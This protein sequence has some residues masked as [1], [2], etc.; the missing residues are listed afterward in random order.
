VPLELQN[1]NMMKFILRLSV[2]IF[3]GIHSNCI[4]SQTLED[5]KALYTKGEYVKAG[6]LYFL[7]YK[8]K[9]SEEAYDKYIALLRKEKKTNDIPEI[10]NL[11]AK[12][13]DAARMLA[14]CENIQIIDSVIVN[15]ADFLKS[16]NIL[17]K[18]SGTI[19]EINNLPVYENQLKDKRY[20]AKLGDERKYR[21]HSQIKLLNKWTD[22]KLLNLAVDADANDN[23]PFVLSDGITIYYASTGRG[24][25]GGYDLFVTRYNSSSDTY[26]KP[27]RLGMPFN[28]PYND[29]MLAIDEHNNVGY[30]ASDRFQ[31]E[32][33]VII[34]TFIPNDEKITIESD[35][36]NYLINR[37]KIT[38]IK[39][40]QKNG[41]DYASLLRKIKSER[42]DYQ[43]KL[44]REFEFVI[45]DD[46]IY[47]KP[48]DFK[49]HAAKQIFI[50]YRESLNQLKSLN[51]KLEEKRKKYIEGNAAQKNRL[52]ESILADEKKS[53]E[54]TIQCKEMAV[55]IRNAE[56]KHLRNTQ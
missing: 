39:Q 18:E 32:G 4:F 9:E 38:S 46:M 40:S 28:S 56:I 3:F 27:E 8:F 5:A 10:E 30:F 16:Y 19:L 34:Y 44:T 49:S 35:D 24:S 17:S 48:D 29:Y 55:E 33:K 50:R 43:E 37:A 25:I 41:V 6:K 2:V 54:L 1:I 51:E 14:Y 31:P 53:E 7:Q 26:F 23:Y 13:K 22:E 42:Q 45:N 20:Y 52:S 11:I 12:S 36:E 47:Y 21:L 15:K